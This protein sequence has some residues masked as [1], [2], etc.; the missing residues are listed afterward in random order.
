MGIIKDPTRPDTPWRVTVQVNG[1]RR[2]RRFT[3]RAQAQAWL[4]SQ[5]IVSHEPVEKIKFDRAIRLYLDHIDST[6]K[7]STWRDHN[8]YLQLWSAWCTENG[9]RNLTDF[10]STVARR[11]MDSI[12]AA[13]KAIQ[14][15]NNR[16]NAIS[17]LCNWAV[18]RGYL[19]QNPMA[20]IKCRRVPKQKP[21]YF[22]DDECRALLDAAWN[23]P[24]TRHMAPLIALSLFAGL[25]LDEAL[26]LPWSACNGMISIDERPDGWT[27]KSHAG[28]REI[29]IVPAL[30]AAL[31]RWQLEQPKECDYVIHWHGRQV[32]DINHAWRRIKMIVKVQGTF[33]QLR[34][35]FA[36]R[37]L[38]AGKI[39]LRTLQKIMGH[40]NLTTTA[41]YL[42]ARNSVDASLL[43][44]L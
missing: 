25:R 38:R 15:S 42:H 1:K 12:D 21:G 44:D 22:T 14:T 36:T 24:R 17:A 37:A 9:C 40:E 33:H 8:Y 7:A 4:D 41:R 35:T 31:D 30:Q 23:A 5:R 13:A 32:K 16:R 10:T 39:D 27:P 11:W 2:Q 6:R 19:A 29:P 18:A 43:P 3:K 20:N 26:N 34:H 28:R